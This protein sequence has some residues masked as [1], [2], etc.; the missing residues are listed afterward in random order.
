MSDLG[1]SDHL[2]DGCV[3][4]EI[5]QG[6]RPA[7]L[8]YEDPHTL[9]FL[10]HQPASPGHTLVIPKVHVATVFELDAELMA[11]LSQTVLVVA[12]AIRDE[13]Q[14]DGLNIW[15]S[16][17]A[18]AGQVVHHV[19]AHL[20]PRHAGDNMVHLYRPGG[21]SDRPALDALAARLARRVGKAGGA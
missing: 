10:D 4:C 12:R 6:R 2:P 21:R 19:H 3:F 14:P 1:H 15:Q 5:V 8:V 9:A 7:A 18:A 17:G 20:L 11:R 13:L 16:N